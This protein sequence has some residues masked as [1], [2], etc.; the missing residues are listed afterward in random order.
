MEHL[1][2]LELRPFL[3]KNPDALVV[4]VREAWEHE[5]VNIP[6][7]RLIPLKTLPEKAADELPRHEQPV[8]LHCHHGMRSL[9]A[10]E[11]LETQG[12]TRLYNLSG[13]IARYAAEV[14]PALPQY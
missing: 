5:L 1:T 13:G 2:P 12:Y 11:F 14:D 7:A 6:G 10:C 9:R 8:V 4:D 3:E